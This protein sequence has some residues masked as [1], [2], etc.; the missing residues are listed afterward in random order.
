MF[1][2]TEQRDTVLAPVDIPAATDTRAYTRG[3]EAKMKLKT[4]VLVL[5]MKRLKF[6]GQDGKEF[7]NTSIYYEE[8]LGAMDM[9][10]V[11]G[12]AVVQVR[13]GDANEFSKH[14][15]AVFPHKAEIEFNETSDGKG[16]TRREVLS[17]RVV[18]G[19]GV[20]PPLPKAA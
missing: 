2:Y 9:A 13:I 4:E 12:S 10:D 18:P 6:T 16:G 11:R 20:R 8:E 3:G 1:V 17:Y 15:Q 14:A 7:S 19:S 5:G